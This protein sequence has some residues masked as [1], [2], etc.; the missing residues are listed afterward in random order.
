MNIIFRYTALLL[1]LLLPLTMTARDDSD[2]PILRDTVKVDFINGLALRADMLGLLQSA[3][4]DHG[5]YELGLRVNIL[6]RYF[7]ALE[8]GLGFKDKNDG[9]TTEN[10]FKARAPYFR[11]GCDMNIL[12]NKHDDYRLY[13][14]ARYGFSSFKYDVTINTEEEDGTITRTSYTDMSGKYHMLDLLLGTDAKIWG[15]LRLGWDVRFRKHLKHSCDPDHEPT[16]VPGMGS[17]KGSQFTGNFNLTIE[18]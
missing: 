1:F 6:D 8:V 4:S 9:Y 11:I 15:P 10:D 13:V 14:G 5:Q 12:K 16:F 17:N 3:I 7:P 18:L 2:E